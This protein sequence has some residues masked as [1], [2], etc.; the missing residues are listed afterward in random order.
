MNTDKLKIIVNGKTIEYDIVKILLPTNAKYKY[1]VYKDNK[2][3]LY[4][5]RF[6]VDNNNNN[7]ILSDLKYK[8][9]FD[10]VN[11]ILNGDNNEK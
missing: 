3:N 7:I 4:S 6:D 5:S 11:R 9:E 10:Y 2:E 8:Y 1:I